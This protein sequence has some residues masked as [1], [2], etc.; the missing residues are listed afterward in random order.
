TLHNAIFDGRDETRSLA[1][2]K[3]KNELRERL[4]FSAIVGGTN[5]ARGA[6]LAVA[7][8]HFND[9]PKDN[10]R[11]V[12]SASTGYI[13]GS[14]VWTLD[15]IQGKVREELTKKKMNAAK[16]S[17]HAKLLDELDDLEQMQEQMSIF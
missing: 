8:F 9:S 11:L 15:N 17:V 4:F 12:A 5:I 13:A 10:F 6:Q 7:G 1:K 3:S 16:L 14:G 2:L